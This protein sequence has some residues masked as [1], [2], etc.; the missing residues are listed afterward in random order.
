MVMPADLE[1]ME[2]SLFVFEDGEICL[3]TN[4]QGVRKCFHTSR[5]LNWKKKRELVSTNISTVQCNTGR[6]MSKIILTF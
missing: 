1:E 4:E 3:K 2:L 5:Q 6:P